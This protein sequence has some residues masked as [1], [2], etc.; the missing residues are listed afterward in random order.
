VAE[1]GPEALFDEVEN[2]LPEAWRDHIRA[3]PIAAVALGVGVGVWLGMKKSDEI[4]TAGS[5]LISTAAMANVA[6]VMEKVKGGA[7]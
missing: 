6:Q 5:T 7:G 2:L 4:I 3:F 1:Q